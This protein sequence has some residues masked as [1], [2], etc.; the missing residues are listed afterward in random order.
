[1]GIVIGWGTLNILRHRLICRRFIRGSVQFS[2]SVVSD[3]LW[4]HELQHARPPCPSPTPWVNPNPCPSSQWCHP[5]ISS[6]I[7]P[8]SCPQSFSASVSFFNELAFAS[9][10][11]N[12]GTSASASALPVNIQGWFPLGLTGFVSLLF[13]GL[14][15]VFSSTT[16]QKHQFSSTQPSL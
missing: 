13:K 9:G 6:S 5:A 3:S 15:R 11:Q 1:M 7:V 4:L 16:V 2:W 8:F 14:S 10:G 12:I